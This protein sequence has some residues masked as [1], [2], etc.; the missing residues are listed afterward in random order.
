MA[1][2][3]HGGGCPCGLQR[4]CDCGS[5]YAPK[6]VKNPIDQLIERANKI[7]KPTAG[8]GVKHDGGKP[9]LGLIPRS[10][11]VAEARVLDFGKR[12][13]AAHNWRGGMEW[14]RLLD[15]ALR[16]LTAWN[17]GE[18]LD[19]ESGLNHLAHARCC[20][21]FLIEYQERGLGHDDRFKQPAKGAA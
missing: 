18:D 2:Y 21:G 1:K 11:L 20:L 4:E 10:A 6:P 16:H 8:T 7:E 9:P 3:D 12:K 14:S 15:A 19:P 5:T 13:Y 17:E